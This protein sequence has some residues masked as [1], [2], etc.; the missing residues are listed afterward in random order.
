MVD[1][2]EDLLLV[3][4]TIATAAGIL[5]LIQPRQSYDDTTVDGTHVIFRLFLLS[6]RLVP[7]GLFNIGLFEKGLVNMTSSSTCREKVGMKVPVNKTSRQSWAQ[8][9]RMYATQS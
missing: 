1:S 4:L 8:E 3:I 9:M 2:T 7:R 5:I 6:A